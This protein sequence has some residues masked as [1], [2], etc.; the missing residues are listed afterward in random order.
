MGEV[1]TSQERI[2]RAINLQEC[3]RV[4]AAPLLMYFCAHFNGVS[5]KDFL[6]DMDKQVATV[7]KTFER[8]GGWDAWYFAP[9]SQNDYTMRARWPLEVKTPGMGLPDDAPLPQLNEKVVMKPE[10]YDIIIEE[11]FDK[12][13]LGHVQRMYPS[14]DFNDIF[15]RVVPEGS[16]NVRRF[17]LKWEVERHVPLLS[18]VNIYQPIEVFSF[19]RSFYEFSLD[20]ARRPDKVLQAVEATLEPLIQRALNGVKAIGSKAVWVGGW[21]TGATFI[22]SRQFEK[23]VLPGLKHMVDVFIAEGITPV[24]HFDAK[25]NPFLHYLRELPPK[26]C[27]FAPDQ[28]TDPVAFKNVLGDHMAFLGNV[29]PQVL[30]LGTV[31]ETVQECKKLIDVFERRGLILGTGCEAPFNSKPEN[32]Q[33]LLDTAKTYG[34]RHN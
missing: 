4:S 23:F 29:S 6:N 14:L 13:F 12:W 15:A 8:L 33:A 25:W 1:L 26:K 5:T 2:Q 11:G 30:S 16:A 7:E 18:G 31:D 19:A 3:D 21:R 10:E 22:S 9:G 20:M 34:A 27:I 32:I 24:L 28:E 17:Y